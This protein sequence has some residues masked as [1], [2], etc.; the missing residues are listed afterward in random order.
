MQPAGEE[1]AK[2]KRPAMAVAPGSSADSMKRAS[3]GLL[4]ITTVILEVA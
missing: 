3:V 2:P 1:E 4:D